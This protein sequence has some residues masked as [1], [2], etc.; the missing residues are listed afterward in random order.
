[1]KLKSIGLFIKCTRDLSPKSNNL[2]KA[3]K[4]PQKMKRVHTAGTPWLTD[5]VITPS[6][7]TPRENN[8]SN[9]INHMINIGLNLSDVPSK[10]P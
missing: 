10:I 5:V 2:Q 8:I 6:K 1:M 9:N 7:E 4:S 3:Q